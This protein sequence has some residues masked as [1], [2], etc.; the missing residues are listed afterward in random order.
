MLYPGDFVLVDLD[1]SF[2]MPRKGARRAMVIYVK[3]NG[4]GTKGM[5]YTAG[6]L[7]DSSSIVH[8]SES[9][10]QRNWVTKLWSFS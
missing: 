10:E 9:H 2:L 1:P 5:K 6:L 8:I 7:L 3:E 4:W